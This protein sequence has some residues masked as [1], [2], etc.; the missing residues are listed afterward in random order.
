[1]KKAVV[2][3]SGGLD[4]S[5]V[6]FMAKAG[7][8]TP[9]ALIFDYG[10]RHRREIESAKKIAR[11]AKCKYTVIKINLPWKCSALLDR[12][13]PLR[14]VARVGGIPAT[15]VPSRNLIFL[16]FAASYAEAI[17]ADAIFIGANQIDFSGYPDC[18]R[19]F[20]KALEKTLEV[21][22]KRGVRGKPLKII[23]PLLDKGKSEIIKTGLRLGVPYEMTFSCYRGT[24]LS[25]GRCDS[26]RLRAKGFRKLGIKDPL[27]R[28][29]RGGR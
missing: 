12:K 16:S 3:L 5:T 28:Y 22:T 10:Q 29:P 13:I 6:L 17:K 8:F 21:G 2:L 25:C 24:R 9:H 18:R 20:L 4:S 23:A 26:C 19:V 11:F 15:Y 14:K 27:S 7:G 1:M